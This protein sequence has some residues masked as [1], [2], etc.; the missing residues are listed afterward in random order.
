MTTATIMTMKTVT[1]ITIMVN[2]TCIFGFP[3]K[4]RGLQRLQS[5]EN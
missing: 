3:L 1:T 5:M 2:T 4:L